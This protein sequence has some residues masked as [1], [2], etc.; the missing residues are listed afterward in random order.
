[1]R[2]RRGVRFHSAELGRILVP[3]FSW[4]SSDMNQIVCTAKPAETC[5]STV[6]RR[7]VSK[8]LGAPAL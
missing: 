2:G 3:P 4:S 8:G 1:M 5:I 7:Q 6:F